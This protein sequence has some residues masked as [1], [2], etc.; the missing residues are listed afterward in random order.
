[1]L[2][3]KE[4]GGGQTH[5]TLLREEG[6]G[7][8]FM[9][10]SVVSPVLCQVGSTELPPRPAHGLPSPLQNPGHRPATPQ[11]CPCL[12]LEPTEAVQAGQGLPG[13]GAAHSHLDGT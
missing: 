6:G 11:P 2:C 4:R 1:M 10:S 12:W 7:L 13:A 5:K 8:L 3:T 9:A